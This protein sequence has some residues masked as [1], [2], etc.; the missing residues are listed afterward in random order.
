MTNSEP[1]T[2]KPTRWYTL[3]AR[4]LIAGSLIGLLYARLDGQL[5]TSSI[6]TIPV[7]YWILALTTYLIAQTISTLR[8]SLINAAFGFAAS[9]GTQLRISF[10]GMFFNLCLPT[11]I[12][13]DV[14]KACALGTDAA[15]RVRAATTVFLDRAI[16]LVALLIIAGVALLRERSLSAWIA[17][18]GMDFS[19]KLTLGIVAGS[20]VAVCGLAMFAPRGPASKFWLQLRERVRRSARLRTMT[21]PRRSQF[22]VMGVALM[23]SLVIQFLNVVLVIELAR[24]MGVELPAQCFFVAV[25]GV[26][27][28]SVLPISFNGIGLREAGLATLLARYGLT[29]EI[30]VGLGLAWFV[31]IVCASLL[32]G[33]V[34]AWG[35]RRESTA[36]ATNLTQSSASATTRHLIPRP[37]VVL[38]RNLRM[39]ISV[40]VPVYNEEP[41]LRP[42]HAQLSSVLGRMNQSYEMIFV[43]DGSR[44]GSESVLRTLAA[45]DQHV[46][47]ITFR[48]NFGQT[49]AME[50]GL[51]A[52]TGDTVI[53]IDAD[54]Q[55]DPADIPLLLAKLDEGYDL[56]HGWR[57]HRQDKLWSRKIPSQVANWLISRVTRFPVHDL[58]CTLKAMRREFA[59][60][61]HLYGEMHRFI[62]I[63]AYWNGARCAEVVTRHH[64]RRAG[65]S[66][67]GLSRTFRVV[68]DLITVKYMTQYFVSPMKLFGMAGL[69][70]LL[71]GCV[72]GG[73][74]LAMK[75]SAGFDMTGNPLLLLSA[76]LS[77]AGM[78]F[79]ILGMLGELGVR[80]YFESQQR[81]PYTIRETLNFPSH[82]Q[83]AMIERLDRAA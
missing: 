44:D 80:T 82:A 31:V 25:P 63:L 13:G 38:E 72:A 78:Q 49:A 43:D 26:I 81:R 77:L 47:V 53:T 61:L 18:A 36:P 2:A 48:R 71:A 20:V 9:L 58:G 3:T 23:L 70:A 42:L 30:G 17:E 73:L 50:A 16:G 34:F 60:E 67:Y 69:L 35:R 10:S 27:L 32:G 21:A 4:V 11:S 45:A 41:N 12:G 8:W 46:R 14:Y 24:G 68:L 7:L 64:P 56:V 15:S 62:P 37:E 33:V 57:L 22:R 1:S 19:G 39:S 59:N 6:R 5:V 75:V 52:A 83:D 74:T 40:V 54:L 66:K 28:L 79:I 76:F 65:V 51:H 55:N 29:S